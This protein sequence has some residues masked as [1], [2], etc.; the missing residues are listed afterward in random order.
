[1]HMLMNKESESENIKKFQE[2]EGEL[3]SLMKAGESKFQIV[4]V[5]DHSI[6]EVVRHAWDIQM[7]KRVLSEHTLDV[8]RLPMGKL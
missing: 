4:K 8:E 6:L 2:L 7:M 3:I 5:T 1:M